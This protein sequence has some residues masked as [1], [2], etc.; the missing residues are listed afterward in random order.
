MYLKKTMRG[1]VNKYP[2]TFRPDPANPGNSLSDDWY[3]WKSPER[4]TKLK[5]GFWLMHYYIMSAARADLARSCFDLEAEGETIVGVKTD[6]VYILGSHTTPPLD[7]SDPA[8]LGKRSRTPKAAPNNVLRQIN[9]DLAWVP[10]E[11]LAILDITMNNEGSCHEVASLTKSTDLLLLGEC[12]GAGKSSM[13][14]KTIKKMHELLEGSL[15]V[16]PNNFQRKERLSDGQMHVDTFAHV[17]GQRFT[18]DGESVEVGGEYHYRGD[19]GKPIGF[20]RSI[21][22]DEIH[23]LDSTARALLDRFVAKLR[24]LDAPPRLFATG[25]ASQVFRERL[26]FP[27]AHLRRTMQ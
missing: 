7:K 23:S 22:F 3:V 15:F 12:A 25:D 2:H 10:P 8:Q 14:I 16:V 19:K 11:P 17:L 20:F 21:V 26:E 27:P 1:T 9:R 5:T 13:A 24:G 4:L 6:A 18:D